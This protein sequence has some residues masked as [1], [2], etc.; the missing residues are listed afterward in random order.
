M[1]RIL[2][3]ILM[4]FILSS[5]ANAQYGRVSVSVGVG[6]GGY[7]GY[8]YG[9]HYG[10]YNPGWYYP[11]GYGFGTIGVT[12]IIVGSENKADPDAG[13]IYYDKGLFYK[14]LA[15]GSYEV[16]P[17]PPGAKIPNV[18]DGYTLVKKGY[19]DY[20]YV[21]G[22]FYS[23]TPEGTYEVSNAPI[24]AKVPYLPK[25]GITEYEYK[26]TIYY[27]LNGVYY[28]PIHVG[29]EVMYKIVPKPGTNAD[30]VVNNQLVTQNP[31]PD[32][33]KIT[34]SGVNYYYKEGQFFVVQ[35]NAENLVEVIAPVGITI[36]SL[37]SKGTENITGKDGNLYTKYLNTYYQAKVVGSVYSYVVVSKPD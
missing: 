14:K 26:E 35:M 25:E 10:W 30:N 4:V 13:K 29:T 8:G 20:Y 28:M 5:G 21:A 11:A 34:Y 16:I 33:D 17:A 22:T 19:V 32:Y 27:E 23:L 36:K 7:G 6:Y 37:P 12:A 2:F 1:K 15:D 18:P 24:G 3:T 31:Y 9:G